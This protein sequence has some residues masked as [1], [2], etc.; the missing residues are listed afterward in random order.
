[1]W[2]SNVIIAVEH[3]I[4]F[5]LKDEYPKKDIFYGDIDKAPNNAKVIIVASEFFEL[6]DDFNKLRMLFEESVSKNLVIGNSS[7]TPV[8]FGVDQHNNVP[9]RHI[10]YEDII[11]TSFFLMFRVEEL[12]YREKRDS[13]GR[14]LY[15]YSKLNGKGYIERP[16]VDEY[17][18]Y[19]LSLLDEDCKRERIKY[20]GFSKI[21]LTHDVDVPFRYKSFFE[22][23]KQLLK[24][25]I[26]NDSKD[27]DDNAIL[28]F[29][30]WTDDP[31]YTFSFF[32]E[33]DDSILKHDSENIVEVIYFIITARSRLSNNYCSIN[34]KK[35]QGLLK[36]IKKRGYTIG[37][38]ISL[39]SGYNPQKIISEVNRL[40]HI[41]DT[42]RLKSRNHFL[43]WKEPEDIDLMEAAGIRDDFTMTYAD[44]VGF[45]VGTCRSYLFI[46][47][48]DLCLK[49]VRIHPTIIMDVS[50]G[51]EK[52]MNS[53]LEYAK[54][55]SSKLIYKV[56]EENGELVLLFHNMPIG[57]G[58]FNYYYLYEYIVSLL[59]NDFIGD[60]V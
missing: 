11:A 39:E 26:S 6:Y 3:I 56:A 16:V 23:G 25:V 29:F 53:S 46:N 32:F 57:S 12:L 1:M 14:F 44:Q 52:Y 7:R 41:V 13:Y 43:R 51:N 20:R 34:S 8:I 27:K 9:Q 45:R 31:N 36:E 5:L 49:E 19:I 30:R 58:V 15:S 2:N 33:K 50:F 60:D 59:Q 22:V 37:L 54:D 4:S 10:I 40:K 38:H 24:N 47:P 48:V 42:K 17:S 55:V 35:Y 28:H 21:Y 18:D